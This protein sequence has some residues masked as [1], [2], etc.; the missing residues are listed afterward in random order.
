MSAA[1]K[2]LERLER[3]KQTAPGR[4]LARCPAHEDK[5]P[6]LSVRELE[7]GRTL[8]NCF[9]GCGAIDVLEALGVDWSALFPEPVPGHKHAA[10]VSRIP[11]R[12]LLQIIS[13][14]TSVV[15][16]IAADMLARKRMSE[17]DWHRLAKAS[18]RIGVARDH[19]HGG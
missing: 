9:A 2:L 6:S 19:A 13:E 15:A 12:D 1:A 17:T 11:P 5:S 3:V 8:V 4:W 7:D 10:H 18:A 14:E 16:I